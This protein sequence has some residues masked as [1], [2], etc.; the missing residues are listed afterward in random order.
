[1]HQVLDAQGVIRCQECA[2]A[3]HLGQAGQSAREQHYRRA[4]YRGRLVMRNN[5]DCPSCTVTI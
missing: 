3:G 4:A 2:A 5:V 1:M